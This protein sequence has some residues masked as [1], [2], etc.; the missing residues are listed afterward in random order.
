MASNPITWQN[1]R[2]PSLAEAVRPLEA[3][4]NGFSSMFGSF[5]DILKQ[6]QATE[7]ANWDQGKQNNT[8]AFLGAVQEV[9]NSE[10][11]AAREA[12]LRQQ[13][14][15]YGAQVDATAGRNAL[16]GRL[17]TLQQR[18]TAGWAYDNAV[19]DQKEAPLVRAIAS[20]NARQDPLTAN[21]LMNANPDLRSMPALAAA[22]TASQRQV[23]ADAQGATTFERQGEKHVADLA[24]QAELERI[25][26]GN[27]Q[28]ARATAENTR[29][30]HEA[31]ANTASVNAITRQLEA[32]K[33]L[34]AAMNDATKVAQEDPYAKQID[35]SSG[36]KLLSQ[37]D[38]QF[39]AKGQGADIMNKLAQ[40]RFTIPVWSGD[41]KD[42]KITGSLPINPPQ[43]ILDKALANISNRWL[44]GINPKWRTADAV[45]SEV[46]TLL[47]DEGE[48]KNIQSA[49]RALGLAKDM[50]VP[51][52]EKPTVT[53]AEGAKAIVAGAKAAT[54]P[55]QA[56]SWL[57][58]VLNVTNKTPKLD[59]NGDMVFS[60]NGFDFSTDRGVSPPKGIPMGA[61]TTKVLDGDTIRIT[62]EDGKTMDVRIGAGDAQE[63]AHKGK[64]GQAGGKASM[65]YLANS[66]MNSGRTQ[67]MFTDNK[68]DKNGRHIAR[69]LVNGKDFTKSAIADGMMVPL[70]IGNSVGDQADN[71]ALMEEAIR[72]RKG[73]FNNPDPKNILLP[74]LNRATGQSRY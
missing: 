23:T 24:H 65:E 17:S 48:V 62:G 45:V 26:R 14:M 72:K 60:R 15:G 2:G 30:T 74:A 1:V 11:F 18:A 12:A 21:L 13:L 10:E 73:M 67:L 4:Q 39:D 37:I 31:T 16:D 54:P 9:K 20:A 7:T 50:S 8:N 44:E 68:T 29:R 32:S 59:I 53:P 66:L 27:L 6:R 63:T 52:V 36:S 5:E 51:G 55:P 34:T 71:A 61:L 22:Y 70:D 43:A 57:P 42:R 38:T 69:L 47:N 49:Q 46:R 58:N 19:V 40:T 3:A 64:E 25:A 56:S 41:G 28:V 33:G 35:M